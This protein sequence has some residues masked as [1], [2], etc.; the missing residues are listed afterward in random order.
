MVGSTTTRNASERA[1]S[2]KKQVRKPARHGWEPLWT[3]VSLDFHEDA[4]DP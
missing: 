2:L 4:S 1:A 3:G